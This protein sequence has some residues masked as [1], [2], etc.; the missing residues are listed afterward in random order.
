MTI[1]IAQTQLSA[2]LARQIEQYV[3]LVERQL[4]RGELGIEGAQHRDLCTKEC[5]PGRDGVGFVTHGLTLC[6]RTN[7]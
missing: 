6:R 3:V 4:P 7:P 2:G 5:F 1:E